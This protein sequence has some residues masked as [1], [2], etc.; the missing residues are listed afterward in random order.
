MR[1]AV[2][3]FALQIAGSAVV[4]LTV[5]TITENRLT[6]SATDHATR[7]RA[8]LLDGWA[9]GGVDGV[10]R[11]A[12]ARL[13]RS[14][15]PQSVVL[16]M[17]RDGRVLAGNVA[18]WPPNIVV[19][20]P[21]TIAIF[22][23]ARAQPEAMRVIGTVLPD[24]TR[25]LT[26]HVI[27]G[28]LAFVG[29]MEV[30][31]V[32]AMIVALLLAGLAGWAA[33]RLIAARL[34]RTAQTVAAVTAGDLD[35]RVA[36]D[37]GNDA[38]EALGRSVNAML[39]RIATLVGELKLA[40]DGLAHDLRSPL[41]RLRA[42]LERALA[43]ADSEEGRVAVLR[44]MEEGDR[45]LGMLDTALRITRA[46]AGIGREAFQPVD[47][48]AL[49]ADVADMFEPVAEDRGLAIVVAEGD[50]IT[51]PANREMIGQAV[52]NLVDNALKYGAGVIRLG[53]AEAG[54]AVTITVADNGPGIPPD[55]RADALRRF[56]RLDA[57]R[58][59]SGA[60]LG[61]SLVAAVA[62]LHGGTLELGDN[63]PGLA[64]RMTVARQVPL[65]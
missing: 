8:L 57:A 33:A 53:V 3:V 10:V 58:T 23:V 45:L 55:R 61:L 30:A 18:A 24:G 40:T 38:F 22:R 32:A 41:T 21:T 47:L 20:P 50:T 43:A 16:V 62:H 65:P 60:G 7:L 5:R 37:G 34:G 63:A 27:E 29:A 64:V 6:A 13:D 12:D 4:L 52:A 31:M 51:V 15:R 28:E 42:T 46:E 25:L 54:D 2:L 19:G 49:V 35:R 17:R 14:D 11:A 48:S 56:G 9:S 39:D 1:F 44:A 59:K 36:L 26:G